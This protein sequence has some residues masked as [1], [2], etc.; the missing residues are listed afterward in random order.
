MAG[1]ALTAGRSWWILGI[2]NMTMYIPD[3]AGNPM[4]ATV[5]EWGEW[6]ETHDN[7][8]AQEDVGPFFV[9]TIF[10]GLDYR[11][12]GDGPPLVYETMWFRGEDSGLWDRYSTRDA[13]LAGHAAAVAWAAAQPA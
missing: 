2:E 13:A 12:F 7:H 6:R 5:Q 10:A 11:F 9:S 8:V 1:A 4:R 3:K